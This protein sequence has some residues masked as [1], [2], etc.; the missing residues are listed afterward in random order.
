[1]IKQKGKKNKDSGFFDFFKTIFYAVIIAIIFR[2]LFFEPYNIPSGSM[3]P[4]LLI[5]DYL[6]VSKYSYGYSR[7]SFPFGIIPLPK[8]RIFA[9]KPKRGDVAVFKLP[10]KTSINYIKRVIG[11]P[12]DTIQMKSG[13][14]FIN[15]SLVVE[16]NDGFYKHIIQNKFEQIYEKKK[17]QISNGKSFSTLNLFNNAALDNTELF[18][19]PEN[20]Y[21]V[22]GDNRDNSLDS[23]AKGGWFVPLENFV[24]K[25][26]IIFF[27]ISDDTRFWQFWKWPF[28]IRYNRIFKKIN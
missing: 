21:F 11:L 25:G 9:S 19:V 15:G 6:F 7:Y 18:L 1:M 24:G 23:R 13:R 3:L 12:G 5:G 28:N 4:N 22:M 10:S 16:N 17:E 2:S 27:S 26:T 20:H 14:L 8:N